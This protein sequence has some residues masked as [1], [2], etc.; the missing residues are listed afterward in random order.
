VSLYKYIYIYTREFVS[1]T[2]S[3]VCTHTRTRRS[4]WVKG[5]RDRGTVGH[6]GGGAEGMGGRGAEGLGNGGS[7]WE[8]VGYVH[9]LHLSTPMFTN[10]VV[11]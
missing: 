4:G 10:W 5:Q 7:E 1:H 9:Q 6:R 2:L 8:N 11:R 3:L